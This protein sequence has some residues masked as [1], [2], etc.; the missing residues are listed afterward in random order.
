MERAS[1]TMDAESRTKI[2]QSKI[3]AHRVIENDVHLGSGPAQ[4][5]GSLMTL[6]RKLHQ[7]VE[8]AG[9]GA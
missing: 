7:G 3:I 2:I 1:R 8:L 6:V 9:A 5:H 4:K